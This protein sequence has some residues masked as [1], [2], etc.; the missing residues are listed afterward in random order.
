MNRDDA[1]KV[2]QTKL[3]GYRLAR[4]VPAPAADEDRDM[5]I[6]NGP[7]IAALRQ[8]FLQP[9]DGQDAADAGQPDF[10]EP[11]STSISVRVEPDDGGPAKTADVSEN[12]EVKIVQG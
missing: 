5:K 11:D 8:K 7:S 2:I 3:P 4:A 10:A 1:E 12:G 9:E 6:D